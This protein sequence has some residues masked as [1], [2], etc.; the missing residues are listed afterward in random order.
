MV[1]PRLFL[2]AGM[3]GLAA[4]AACDD[5]DQA[6]KEEE[7]AKVTEPQ[8]AAAG[9]EDWTRESGLGL[10]FAVPPG[11]VAKL[12]AARIDLEN[13]A[14]Y[15]SVDVI[16]LYPE[17]PP[18]AVRA[19]D[20][21]ILRDG[22]APA[23]FTLRENGAGSGGSNYTLSTIKTV[24]GRDIALLAVVETEGGVPSFAE[25]WAVWESLRPAD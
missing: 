1:A 21:P 3:L 23:R 8:I 14:A 13:P 17:G 11:R 20:G 25:A 19:G 9:W 16:E 6:A 24:G 10:S 22:D 15:R 2:L 12:Q 7:T 4:L 5:R 18:P